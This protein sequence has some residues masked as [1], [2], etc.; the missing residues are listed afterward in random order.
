MHAN[1]FKCDKD[2]Y[3]NNV[4]VYAGGTAKWQGL[5]AI[6]EAYSKIEKSIK[7]A[8]FLFLT[9][10][11]KVAQELAEKYEIKNYEIDYVKKEDLPSKLS[12]CK[13]GFVL[14]DDTLINNVS[15]PTKLSTYLSCGVIPIF[16]SSILDFKKMM[17]NKK[18]KI[19]YNSTHFLDDIKNMEVV[20]INEI[21]NE[22]NDIFSSYYSNDYY[23]EKISKMIDALEMK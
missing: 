8:K 6:V 4:F 14:R 16:S 13:F 9:N 21:I 1:A 3:K 11:F 17:E 12:L 10:D 23:V 2:K 5:D 18:Y 20:D 15:T 22:Y 7:N 19:V